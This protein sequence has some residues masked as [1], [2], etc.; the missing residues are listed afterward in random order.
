[1]LFALLL[2]CFFLSGFSALLYETVWSREFAFVFGT[3]EL[4]VVAVLAAYMGGLALGAALAARWAPRIR[5][6]I[7]VY[8]VLEL[9]IALWAL[10]VPTAIRAIRGVYLGWLGGLE[11]LPETLGWATHAFHLF[12]TFLVLV[13]CTAL[14]G[15]TLPLLAR[16]AVTRDDQIGPRVGILYATN[17]L[18]AIG[19]T[20]AAAFV[21]LPAFGLRHTV[22]IGAGINALVF[23]A[24]ALLSRAAPSHDAPAPVRT[25]G[26]PWI[27]PL[28]AVSGAVSFAYEVLWFRMLGH[29]LG[30]STAAFST[31][32]ASFLAGIALGSAFASRFA[33]TQR[34]AGLGFVLAQ[35]LTASL[36]WL[37]FLAADRLPELASALGA[38]VNSLGPGALVSLLSLMPLTLCI[39]T[40][41]PFA[42]RLLARNAEEA[43]AS[44][45]RV[46]AWNTVGSIFGAV[47]TGYVLLPWLGLEGTLMAGATASL[48]LAGLAAL[49]VAP[50]RPLLAGAAVAV[51][52]ALTLIGA[53]RPDSLLRHSPFGSHFDGEFSYLGVGRS[54]TVSVVQTGER[55]RLATNG[56]PES[57]VAPT[58]YPR[59][60][61][62]ARWLSMLPVLAR[63]NASDMLIIGLGGGITVNAVSAQVSNVEV[64]ELEPEV[65]VANRSLPGREGGDPLGEPRI[66]LR[67]GDARGALILA[68]RRYDAIV[69]QP[70]HPWTSG[71]S[72]LYTREFFQL[73]DS[74]LTEDG[75][76]VQWIGSAFVDAPRIGSLLAALQDVFTHVQTFWVQGALVM[77]SSQAPFDWKASVPRAIAAA[78][79]SFAEEGIHRTEDVLA[80]LIADEA[81]TRELAAGAPINS[82]DHNRLA[83]SNHPVRN[84]SRAWISELV[85]SPPSL[86]HHL[87]DLDLAVLTR[88]MWR[89]G[90][91]QR[92][93]QLA[94]VAD[95]GTQA[96]MLGWLLFEN[97]Q[98]QRAAALFRQALAADPTNRDAATGLALVDP[99]ADLGGLPAAARSV[100]L[101][102]R[103]P[104]GSWNELRALDD[105]LATWR[106]GDLLYREA[107]ELRARWRFASGEPARLE[108]ALTLVNEMLP[109]DYLPRHLLLRAELLW[110]T[111]RRDVAAATLDA[112]AQLLSARPAPAI[113]RRAASI[114]R[115][116]SPPAAASVIT[117]LEQEARRQ[118]RRGAA[119]QAR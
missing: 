54:A 111:D 25:G 83:M 50:R 36:A 10:A 95:S 5:R 33:K 59:N 94:E 67:V 119:A 41:F 21:L 57:L 19:G 30:A 74:R 66:S 9:A 6:P 105:D 18:G 22:W 63:P 61:T 40:T 109:R 31:M 106:P 72:H 65:V 96:L 37:G 69:S 80:A 2:T 43:T 42:V 77:V 60:L 102:R 1:M 62:A 53:P 26:L 4:A 34:A 52:V 35:L 56:L 58:G 115:S 76:F 75:V 23:A 114:A 103:L 45:A 88:R 104:P 17:T 86:V 11:A 93:K 101:G 3:S 39:G 84:G 70:S 113:A 68:D 71:A 78:P 7:W 118:P 112:L 91:T 107:N 46:Y 20:L 116:L 55:W 98:P 48:V 99:E 32:L 16:H 38:N 110:K 97:R 14:M 15:A 81:K 51:A 47:G 89:M 27:L 44:S 90:T 108:E 64:I 87:D 100:A 12:G 8:G 49:F 28:I 117:G 73:V 13:P 92:V 82:D 85:D 24:A 79:E 29:I